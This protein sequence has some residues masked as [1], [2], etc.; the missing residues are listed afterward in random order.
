ML[1]FPQG[2]HSGP[3]PFKWLCSVTLAY[4]S[5][6]AVSLSC[7]PCVC[8][9][10]SVEAKVLVSVF[11]K[12]SSRLKP[13]TSNS[14]SHHSCHR[15]QFYTVF[16]CS[17]HNAAVTHNQSVCSRLSETRGWW[18]GVVVKAQNWWAEGCWFEWKLHFVSLYYIMVLLKMLSF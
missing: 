2:A 18:C 9:Y 7:S 17:S 15:E 13:I 5:L 8:M 6:C 12:S 16:L 3:F 4:I 14:M 1:W 10:D 11:S